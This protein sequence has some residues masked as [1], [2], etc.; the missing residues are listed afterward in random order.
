MGTTHVIQRDRDP[1]TGAVTLLPVARVTLA[2]GSVKEH[3]NAALKGTTNRD[4]SWSLQL[5]GDANPGVE[6]LFPCYEPG[7]EFS[8]FRSTEEGDILVAPN[9][10]PLF[11]AGEGFEPLSPELI[12]LHGVDLPAL[13]NALSSLPA[14]QA[15]PINAMIAMACAIGSSLR[16]NPNML[17]LDSRELM[18][19]QLDL[20]NRL[21]EV[22]RAGYMTAP[23]GQTLLSLLF[24][25]HQVEFPRGEPD[26]NPIEKNRAICAEFLDQAQ[27]RL[28]QLVKPLP[29]QE[30]AGVLRQGEALLSE[31]GR[32]PAPA[33]A[34]EVPFFDFGF[35]PAAPE[36]PAKPTQPQVEPA[37]VQAAEPVPEVPMFDFSFG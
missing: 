7:E 25:C 10:E 12:E 36:S 21:S 16:Y 18:R 5:G 33:P 11:V 37:R 31:L 4:G 9:G 3:L 13:D 30:A 17:G 35:E 23:S 22:L 1:D 24:L 26:A 32:T 2:E 8:G 29:S 6:V 14:M 27:E 15:P 19:R 28:R 34:Q 20:G